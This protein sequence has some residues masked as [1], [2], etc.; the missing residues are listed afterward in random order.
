MGQVCEKE[1]KNESKR[2]LNDFHSLYHK[3]KYIFRINN[4]DDN[5]LMIETSS[6]NTFEKLGIM[7]Q[8]RVDFIEEI[9]KEINDIKDD[10]NNNNYINYQDYRYSKRNLRPGD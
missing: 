6:K 3:N 2:L 4:Y 10:E 7:N 9:R 1:K 8:L 5:C